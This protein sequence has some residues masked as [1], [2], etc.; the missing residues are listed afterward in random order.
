M[1]KAHLSAFPGRTGSADD[2]INHDGCECMLMVQ[3]RKE[4]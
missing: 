1:K 3:R 4:G 2:V